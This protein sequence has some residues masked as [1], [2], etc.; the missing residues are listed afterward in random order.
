[1]DDRFHSVR[2]SIDDEDLRRAEER[3]RL[4]VES[5]PAAMVIVDQAA[6]IVMVNRQTE[7]WFGY[8]REEL[9]GQAVEFLIPARF[10]EQHRTDRDGFLAA[11]RARP[12]GAGHELFGRRRDN[13]EFPGGHQPASDGD[14]G[15]ARW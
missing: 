12:M 9:I 14:G 10:H 5:A 3:F 7:N 2:P 6:R 11:P 1:M 4:V 15:D 13:S 8:S